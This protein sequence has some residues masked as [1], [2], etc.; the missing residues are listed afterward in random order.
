VGTPDP[1]LDSP[2]LGGFP[3]VS[4]HAAAALPFRILFMPQTSC[5]PHGAAP[6]DGIALLSRT[7]EG[8]DA[9]ARDDP[10]RQISLEPTIRSDG[11]YG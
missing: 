4:S 5:R 3:T 11:Q 7:P 6:L 1:P 8:V 9:I 10:G 2:P